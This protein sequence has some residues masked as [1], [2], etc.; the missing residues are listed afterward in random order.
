MSPLVAHCV[1]SRPSII[2]LQ[3]SH[4]ITLLASNNMDCG[5]F[6]SPFFMTEILTYYQENSRATVASW[7]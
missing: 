1:I 2:A 3:N 4:S 7:A 6:N 5:T